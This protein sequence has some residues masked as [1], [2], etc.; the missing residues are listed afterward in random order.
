MLTWNKIF[1][2]MSFIRL[3]IAFLAASPGSATST[4]SSPVSSQVTSTA[5]WTAVVDLSIVLADWSSS[6]GTECSITPHVSPDT[7][8]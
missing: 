3:R 7:G 5:S 6:S 2:N 8:F 1:I 4:H